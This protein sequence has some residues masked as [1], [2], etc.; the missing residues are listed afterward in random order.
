M[1][2]LAAAFKGTGVEKIAS[3]C[4]INATE[5]TFSAVCDGATF[6]SMKSSVRI[7]FYFYFIYLLVIYMCYHEQGLQLLHQINGINQYFLLILLFKSI[8]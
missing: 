3:F 5:E 6:S 1:T 8:M 2:S 4:N 7:Y